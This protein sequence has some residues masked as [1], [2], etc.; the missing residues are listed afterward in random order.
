MVFEDWKRG[1]DAEMGRKDN[2]EMA[3]IHCKEETI[4]EESVWLQ[5]LTWEDARRRITDAQNTIIVPV[6]STEQHGYH[7]PLGSDTY[8]AITLAEDGARNAGV[9]VA[10]P[11]WFGWSPHHMVLPGTIT[12]RPEILSELLYDIIASLRKHGIDKFVLVNGHRIVNVT[13]M[14]IAAERVKRQLGAQV[15]IFDPA[16]MSKSI[17]RKL[18][19]G[20]VGHA[21]E[22]ESSHMW[23]RYPDRVKMERAVDNPHPPKVLY[24]VDPQYPDDTLCYVPSSPAEMAASVEV[25]GGT[26]GEP[27]KASMEGGRQY[28]D[29]LVDRLVTV[30]QTLQQAS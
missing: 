27:S 23:Y 20:P 7:L 16:Y 21:E 25:A 22:I 17:T 9:L 29:H 14:Q 3:S 2:F 19:W 28:H 6:G 18:H 26:A 30:I 4:M 24:S 10:P 15:V 13:W 1:H 12:V 8:V 5:D 11:L